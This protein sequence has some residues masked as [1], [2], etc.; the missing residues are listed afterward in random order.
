M[1]ANITIRVDKGLLARLDAFREG[2]ELD[3]SRAAVIR[4][5]LDRYITEVERQR[6]E[7][8]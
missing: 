6:E 7:R 1:N 5:A 8:K 4:A 2:Y 3:I